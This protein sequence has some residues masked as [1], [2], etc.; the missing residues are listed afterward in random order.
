MSDEVNSA[1]TSFHQKLRSS[2]VGI[3]FRGDPGSYS[4]IFQLEIDDKI[5]QLEN[6]DKISD[7][8]LDFALQEPAYLFFNLAHIIKI[9]TSTFES[10]KLNSFVV[11]TPG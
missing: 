3:R 9:V 1:L 10:D 8:N 7:L 11:S 2:T 6:D 4:N 5:F